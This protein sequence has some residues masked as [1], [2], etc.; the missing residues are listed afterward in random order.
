MPKKKTAKKPTKRKQ[1]ELWEKHPNLKKLLVLYVVVAA[2]FF[3]LYYTHF[4]YTLQP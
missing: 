1:H 3:L 2:G 4:Q